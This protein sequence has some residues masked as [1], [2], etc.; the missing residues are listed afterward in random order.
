MLICILTEMMLFIVL[1]IIRV[2]NI[3]CVTVTLFLKII[4]SMNE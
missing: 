1:K 2:I 3:F 4:F